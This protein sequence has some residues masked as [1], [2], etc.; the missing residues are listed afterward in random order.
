MPVSEVV[1]PPGPARIENAAPITGDQPRPFGAVDDQQRTVLMIV[2][3][4]V[5]TPQVGA[6]EGD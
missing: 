2:A 5:G 3:R 1:A 4:G 6:I